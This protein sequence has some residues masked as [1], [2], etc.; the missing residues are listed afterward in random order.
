MEAPEVSF[1][2]SLPKWNTNA[3]HAPEE[4]HSLARM[5]LLL[6]E[7]SYR[8]FSE[9]RKEYVDKLDLKLTVVLKF[10]SN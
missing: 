6:I 2:L 9:V 4:G 7:G 5:R 10:S 3:L 1:N 8:Y